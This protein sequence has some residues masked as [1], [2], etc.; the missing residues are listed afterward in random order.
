MFLL[1]KDLV[2]KFI[3]F[4]NTDNFEIEIKNY[5]TEFNYQNGKTDIIAQKTTNEIV[6][7]EAKLFDIK[8]VINQAY[9]NTT[10]ANLSYIVL[11]A[12]KKNMQT[13]YYEEM[14]KLNIG[15][16]LV[17]EQHAWIEKEASIVEPVLP[18]LQK[19]ASALLMHGIN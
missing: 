7:F 18:W 17:D 10:F 14:G 9:R 8:K 2:D 11:P 15:L 13:K 3:S 4:I 16:I 1:E 19:K 5:C 6:A 12:T